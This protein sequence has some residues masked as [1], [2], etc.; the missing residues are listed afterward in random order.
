M[1]NM[2]S[3]SYVSKVMAKVKVFLGHKVTDRQRG[4]KLDAPEFHSRDK[5][6]EVITKTYYNCCLKGTTAKLDRGCPNG[7]NTPRGD[8]FSR[9]Q[10]LHC[11]LDL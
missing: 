7:T 1:P 3:I 8:N 11:D 5:K 9:Y 6:R 4:Q 10:N 2:K